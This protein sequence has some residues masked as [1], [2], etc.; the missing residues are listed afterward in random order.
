M[1][2]PIVRVGPYPLLLLFAATDSCIG[3]RL[4][5]RTAVNMIGVGGTGGAMLPRTMQR[6]RERNSQPPQ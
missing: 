4:L 6:E 5:V 2:L 1:G 3:W